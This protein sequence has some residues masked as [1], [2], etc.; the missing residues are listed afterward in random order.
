MIWEM[1]WK[2]VIYI[3]EM[4]SICMLICHF[5]VCMIYIY[6]YYRGDLMESKKKTELFH[7]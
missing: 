7:I 2:W 6:L 1:I 5:F 4:R 3:L